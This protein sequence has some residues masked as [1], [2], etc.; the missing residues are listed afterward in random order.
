MLLHWRFS[1]FAFKFVNIAKIKFQNYWDKDCCVV[2][3]KIMKMID[4]QNY[5]ITQIIEPTL[6]FEDKFNFMSIIHN[7]TEQK[8]SN[9]FPSSYNK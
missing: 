9:C 4:Q 3:L 1:C 5:Q 7:K 6:S 2:F 8:I